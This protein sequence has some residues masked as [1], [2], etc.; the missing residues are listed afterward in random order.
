MSTN[1]QVGN[2]TRPLLW[3]DNWGIGMLC[4]LFNPEKDNLPEFCNMSLVQA[5]HDLPSLLPQPHTLLQC[6]L[7]LSLQN[8]TLSSS[9]DVLRWRWEPSGIFSTSSAYNM[10]ITAGRVKSN[11]LSVWSFKTTPTIQLFTFL[12]FRNRLLTQD[13]LLSWNCITTFGCSLCNSQ[14]VETP[15]HLFFTCSFAKD[16]WQHLHRL[17]SLPLPLLQDDC[18]DTFVHTTNAASGGRNRAIVYFCRLVAL[19]R[20][21]RKNFPRRKTLHKDYPS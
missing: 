15:M 5:F 10:M 19:E 13:R 9:P 12:W 8:L 1:W 2:A 20:T 3:F 4:S 21:K 14:V 11:F 6:T 7:L 17:R 18:Y 16:I